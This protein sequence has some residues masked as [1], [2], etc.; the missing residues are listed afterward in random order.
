MSNITVEYYAEEKAFMIVLHHNVANL[1]GKF[2]MR[3]LKYS[4][5]VCTKLLIIPKLNFL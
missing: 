5:I 1:V 2:D 4:K 3:L